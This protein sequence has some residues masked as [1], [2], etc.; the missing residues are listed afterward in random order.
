MDTLQSRITDQ[1][2]EGR[3]LVNLL[4]AATSV[5]I[6]GA[7]TKVGSYSH[8]AM[9]YLRDYGYSGSLYLIN[10]TRD[11]IEGIRCYSSPADLP[12][13]TIELALVATAAE[14]V[15]ASV[16][17]LAEAGAR[18]A[19]VIAS[20]LDTAAKDALREI[21][22][23]SG[24]RIIGPNCIGAVATRN[25][26]Y[27]SFS[28]VLK[29][30]A[31]RR[32][33]V[34]LVTQSG[35][36]GNALMVSLLRRGA[37][38]SHWLTTGDEVNVGALELVAGLLEQA[39]VDAVGVFFEG[40]GDRQ[41]LPAVREAIM[42]TG[43]RVFVV[44]GAQTA[45]GRSAAAG[46]TGRVVGSGESSVAIMRDAGISVL[47]TMAQMADALV[48]TDLL[49]AAPGVRT[50]VVTVSGGC[51]V[52]AA[53]AIVR[54][55]NLQLAHLA[56]DE[57]L[58]ANLGGRVHEVSNP[59]DVAGSPTDVFAEWVN[60]VAA[61]PST[62]VVIAIQA[63]IMHDETVLADTITRPAD[64]T[65]IIV[66]PF[67]EEDPLSTDAIYKL[68]AK[69]IPVMPSADR[70]IA[71]LSSIVSTRHAEGESHSDEDREDAGIIGFEDAVRL[72][73]ADLPWVPWGIAATAEEARSFG[74]EHGFPIVVKVAGR[75]LQHRSDVGGVRV[76][77]TADSVS[78]AF[79]EIAG[80]AQPWK[81]AVLVQKQISAVSEIMVSG[82]LDPE[83]GPIV[84]VRPGGILAEL[85]EG[86]AVLWGGWSSEQRV[87]ALRGSMIGN[88][89]DGYRGGPVVDLAPINALSDQIIELLSS[90]QVEFVELNPVMVQ[91]DGVGLVDALVR[92]PSV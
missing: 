25:H 2:I 61:R 44:K 73:G 81:D 40:I 58:T 52:L 77:V 50:S 45:A 17:S 24:M 18:V 12:Y 82:I 10:P 60:L 19:I 62:D 43:K 74:E 92:V 53:D 71:A 47:Q 41:W 57:V 4:T 3:T 16:E 32:G 55:E 68:A 33:R 75:T 64:G 88:V 78:D 56:S 87:E 67:A 1:R 30:G 63:N 83:L 72:C 13:G 23:G 35:A 39:D 42:R 7:S 31:P 65:P 5:A 89:L 54:S 49:G 15:V 14:H 20:G 46:H 28:A 8:R 6:V 79:S 48:M 66:V 36:M 11:E 51:G 76:G 70:A 37:G 91:L 69:G 85:L 80:I 9:T 86:N 34:A 38:I 90:G 59:L 84:I 21:A 22:E 29:D 27:P 26:V